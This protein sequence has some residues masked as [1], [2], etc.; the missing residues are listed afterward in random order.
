MRREWDGQAE[1]VLQNALAADS[2]YRQRHPDHE[3]E[4]LKS[5]EPEAISREEREELEPADPA[6][7]RRA[8]MAGRGGG[9]SAAAA[10]E[11]AHRA[12]SRVPSEFED[13]LGELAWPERA[14]QERDGDPPATSSGDPARAG[15]CPAE[16]G[17]QAPG[18]GASGT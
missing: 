9:E 17:A 11:L 6:D 2:E 3:L 10:E 4:P 12:T 14:Q 18:E 5:L 7:V 1:R 15:S 8:C 13:E 16:R